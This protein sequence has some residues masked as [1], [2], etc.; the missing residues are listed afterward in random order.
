MFLIIFYIFMGITMI[1]SFVGSMYSG[2][3]FNKNHLFGISLPSYAQYEKEMKNMQDEYKIQCKKYGI[4]YAVTFLPVVFLSNIGNLSMIYFFI[5]LMGLMSTFDRPYSKMNARLKKLKREKEWFIGIKRE[6]LLDTKVSRIKNSMSISIN[7]FL[8]PWILSIISIVIELMIRNNTRYVSNI[9]W[10]ITMIVNTAIVMIL[11]NVFKK[12]KTKV[13]SQNTEINIAINK[14][15]KQ[16]W[17]KMWFSISVFNAISI[18]SIQLVLSKI[19]NFNENIY[20]IIFSIYI[21]VVVTYILYSYSKLK[22]IE[23]ELIV[24]EEGIIYSDDDEYWIKGI[25]YCNPNDRS[26]WVEKSFGVGATVNIGTSA[27]KLIYYISNI[28]I[29]GIFAFM[30]IFLIGMDISEPKIY[31]DNYNKIK[32]DYIMYDFDFSVDE[33]KSINL[34]DKLPGGSRTNGSST[35]EYNMGN[36]HINGYGKSKVYCY[37]NS[38]PIIVI[39]LEDIYVFYNCKN[40]EDTMDVYENL[41]GVYRKE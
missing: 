21:I 32:I 28:F 18:L 4:V 38:S 26:V 29:V 14:V 30:F 41:E 37:H 1:V 34:I 7:W 13:Y 10:P 31:V 6:V 39:E 2:Y 3:K 12:M 36:F 16:W 20:M 19:I 25:I 40:N 9:I 11:Y 35:P 23:N 5:W 27:G 22:D 8:I 15:K 33:I 17:S 24:H